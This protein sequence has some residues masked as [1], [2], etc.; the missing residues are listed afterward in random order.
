MS[1]NIQAKRTTLTFLAQ[2]CP[3]MDLGLGTQKTHIGIRIITLEILCVLIFR[4]KWTTLTFLAKICP[5]M[6]LGLEIQKT[7]VGI[8]ISILKILCVPVF[9]Q[10]G[11]L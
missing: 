1:A 4:Q 2:I 3:K 9:K 5:K 11:Q 6:D 10:N 8:R 7:N